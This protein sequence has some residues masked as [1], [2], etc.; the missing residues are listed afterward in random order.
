MLLED[1]A[2]LS[3]D[4]PKT[5]KADNFKRCGMKISHGWSIHPKRTVCT[6]S[7]VGFFLNEQKYSNKSAW[8]VAG[9]NNWKR[10]LDKMQEHADSEAHLT[11]MERWNTY[12]KNAL[13]A[14]FEVSD[15]Q[16]KAIREQEIQRN[17]IL[18]RLINITLYLARQ[19][20]AFRGDDESATS[21]NQGNFL[22]LVKT[23]SQYD[24]VVQATFQS[25]ETSFG[26]E[27]IY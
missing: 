22:E 10:G 7:A 1:H 16:G 26:L 25:G 3:L 4:F 8:R 6:A 18:T 2:N 27:N 15:V 17:R 23:F 5:L 20:K 9:V 21:S 13:Q 12:K 19:G 24:S 14:A 11:S